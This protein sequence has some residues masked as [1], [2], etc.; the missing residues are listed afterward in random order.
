MDIA[1]KAPT[2]QEVARHA[3]VSAATVSRFL[4]NP[5]RVSEETRLRVKQAVEATGYTINQA[6]RSLRM[7]NART[8]LIALPDIGNPFYSIILDAVV[9]EASTRGYGVLV[10]SRFKDDPAGLLNA[11]FLSSR[12]DGMLLL[13]GGLDTSSLHSLRLQNGH[14]PLVVSYDETTDQRINSVTVDNEAAARRAVEHLIGLGH[15]Q[16]GHVIGLSRNGDPNPRLL[17]YEAAMGAAGLDVRPEWVIQGDYAIGSGIEA[18]RRM[19][20]AGPLP[21]A[22][23]CGND[24][25]AVGLMWALRQQGV[26]CPEDISVVGFD[27]MEIAAY[28]VPT[29]TTMRHPR[30]EIGRVATRVLIDMLEGTAAFDHPARITLPSELVVR[31]STR[32]V[33]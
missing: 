16:I 5:E 21:S 7:R 24:E 17:G 22:V 13:D 15:R 19:L 3:G 2:I 32:R 26:S 23:F 18:A 30:E 14:L 1:R 20:A 33:A 31:Q 29:L 10:A 25:M 12:A 8:L 6:A 28:Y 9:D 4:S 27:D 11:Y